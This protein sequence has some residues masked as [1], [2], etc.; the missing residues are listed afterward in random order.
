MGTTSRVAK[1]DKAKP[2]RSLGQ[3]IDELHDIREKRRLLE[4]QIKDLDE[5][6][7]AVEERLMS[8]MEAANLDKMTGKKGT[9]SITSSVVATVND[10]DAFHAWIAKTKNFQVLQRRVS[11][12]AWREVVE[13][14]KGK[15]P[16]GTEPFSKR[17][18]NLRAVAE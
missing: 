18:L 10:W 4:L 1:A 12:P 11:D 14:S 7:G 2:E 3:D 8:K 13:H 16:P 5:T 9:V 6:Y 15:N 17:R